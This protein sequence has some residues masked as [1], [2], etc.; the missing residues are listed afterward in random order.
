MT[1]L[2]VLIP[3][4]NEMFLKNTID[5]LLKNMRG[6]TEIIAILDGA[7]ADPPIEDNERVTLVYH[8][9]AIG[10]RA[11]T[12]EAARLARG[13]YIM[14]V[15]AHCAFDEGFD[16]KLCAAGEE[17]GHDVTQV[18]RM[19]NLHV[20]D[21]VCQECGQRIYQGPMPV[22]CIKCD[23]TTEQVM[24]VVWQPRWN[25]C[26]DFARFDKTMHFQYWGDFKKRPEAQGDIC[27]LM[28][29]VGAC[30]FMEKDRFWELGGTD[31]EHGS[32]GQMGVE[33]SCK[34]WLSGG[35][36]VVNKRTW[37]SHLFR[38]QPGF[39]FP[40]PQSGR[41]V[42]HARQYS[43]DLWMNNKW[44]KA[45][46]PFQ[47]LLDKFAPVPDWEVSK[48]VLY[49]TDN[50]LD[51]TIM[52]ACQEKLLDSINGHRLVT[53]GLKP[54]DGFGDNL[55]LDLERGH[56][57][58]FKQILAGLEALD[59]DIVYF[60][61]HD[62]IYPPEHFEFTPPD[63]E[64]YY[65]NMNTWKTDGTHYLRYDCKQTSGLVAYRDLLLQHYRERVRRVEAEGYNSRMGFEPGSHGRAERVDDYPSDA[66]QSARPIV[67]IRHGKNLTPSRWRQDQFRDQRNCRNWQEADEVPGWGKLEEILK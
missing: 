8:A 63:R 1:D 50:Q 21:W 20:F 57:T 30:W 13:K 34:S 19:Y 55:T 29:H 7:W 33:I 25:R 62:C 47:W 31:E 66:F 15:D 10:Q 48:G 46:H 26:S 53:V 35:R 39:G 11:A 22:K 3:A 16:V 45:V 43:R 41:Q 60:C 58:M 18:P 40:Y 24:D 37:Y 44:D 64:T 28:C 2:S 4:R 52:K 59:T 27:D 65:Y 42:E 49:Y 17:L 54:M 38:T 14:K 6:D 51:P 9:T 12:N 67:D 5:D 32:W 56:L 36:Q 61:E 23:R